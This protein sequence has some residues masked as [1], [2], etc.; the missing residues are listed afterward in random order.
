MRWCIKVADRQAY[1]SSD[2]AATLRD[3][4][5]RDQDLL[6]RAIR[7][8]TEAD[9]SRKVQVFEAPSDET[10]LVARAGNYRVV[11]RYL[12]SLELP[13][14]EDLGRRDVAVASIISDQKRL[15]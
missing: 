7:R 14:L 9:N 15:F 1:L 6:S 12:P 2:A 13:G 11:F 8:L 4:P 5:K 3:L 10:Y